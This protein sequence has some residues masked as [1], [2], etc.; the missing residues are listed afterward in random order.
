MTNFSGSSR[1]A[2][3]SWFSPERAVLILPIIGGFGLALLLFTVGITPLLVDINK[4]EQK[5]KVLRSKKQAISSLK[6]QLRDLELRNQE[7]QQQLDRLLRLVAGSSELRTFLAQINDLA[8]SHSVVITTTEPGPAE[9]FV[10]AKLE[11]PVGSPPPA[12]L[13][14]LSKQSSNDALLNEGIEKRSA[15]LQVMGPFERVLNFLRALEKLQV[16]VII[17][18]LDMQVQNSAFQASETAS[19]TT[20]SMSAKLSAYGRTKDHAILKELR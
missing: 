6:S 12:A 16:F 8:I 13:G 20:I 2:L 11:Q 3:W 18:D 9:R 1:S 5:V 15:G 17:E 19:L 10:P 7:R 4:Q 14:S